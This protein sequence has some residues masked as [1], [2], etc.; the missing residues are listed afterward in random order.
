LHSSTI[1]GA[2]GLVEPKTVE[3]DN[4][5]LI[6]ASDGTTS[7]DAPRVRTRPKASRGLWNQSPILLPD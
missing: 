6:A 2:N 7:H 1:M 5:G 3:F 4:S